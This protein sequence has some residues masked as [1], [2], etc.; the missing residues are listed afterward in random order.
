MN[1]IIISINIY[2]EIHILFLLGLGA[3]KPVPSS[4][5]YADLFI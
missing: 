1:K 2:K 3:L 5:S 4:K